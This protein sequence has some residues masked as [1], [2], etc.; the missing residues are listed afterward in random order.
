MIIFPAIDLKNGK[1]VR[2][3]QGKFDN[4][5]VF[6]EDPVAVAKEF[7]AK[8]AEYIHLVD[9]DGA[10]EGELVNR[11]VIEK[12]V[13][14]VK[15]PCELGGG[16]RNIERMEE[17]L[18]LGLARVI[19]G[20]IAIKNPEITKEA[21]AKFGGEKV[22]IGIDAKKGKVAINGWLDVTEKDVVELIKEM[23]SIGVKTV[24]YTD[25]EKDGMM[26]GI[27]LDSV[28]RIL[29]QTD[30]NMVVSGGVTSIEDINH[31][32]ELKNSKIE[33]VITGKAIYEG[34]LNLEEAIRVAR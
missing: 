26:Q 31:L 5:K 22:V 23:E 27:S 18:N 14:S 6:N 32:V 16:I 29:E 12:I 11:D 13:K 15:I 3:E 17:L 33:G 24:I 8:G 7:E 4:V 19:L 9:L 25:I 30:I 10:V 2:L 21:V 20:T 28:K 1:C 34:K